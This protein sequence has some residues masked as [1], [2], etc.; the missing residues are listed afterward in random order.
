MRRFPPLLLALLPGAL[1]AQEKPDLRWAFP[2]EQAT[3]EHARL[4]MDVASR[5]VISVEEE[6]PPVPEFLDA[7]R[8]APEEWARRAIREFVRNEASALVE[9]LEAPTDEEAEAL[10]PR[11][12]RARFRRIAALNGGQV[13]MMRRAEQS[14]GLAA[15]KAHRAL[16]DEGA[17]G[18]RAALLARLRSV[19]EGKSEDYPPEVSG[20]A[21]ALVLDRTRPG[22]WGE[23]SVGWK[24]LDALLAKASGPF[25]SGRSPADT[26]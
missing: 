13:A 8:P 11:F 15:Y 14:R 20:F 16:L 12:T 21:I 25:K 10:V 3:S 7:D 22:W 19:G 23:L 24:P 6:L 4:A 17:P 2:E 5:F 18:M 9:A 26:P 1:I